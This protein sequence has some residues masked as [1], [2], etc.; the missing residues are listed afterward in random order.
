MQRLIRLIKKTNV[1]NKNFSEGSQDRTCLLVQQKLIMLKKN[2]KFNILLFTPV[3]LEPL[4]VREDTGEV[5][6]VLCK[7]IKDIDSGRMKAKQKKQIIRKVK[8]QPIER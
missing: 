1:K 3:V 4:V 8:K 7:I 6:W 2:P 5:P